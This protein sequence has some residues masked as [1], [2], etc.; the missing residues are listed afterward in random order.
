MADRAVY[1]GDRI[2][3]ILGQYDVP[4]EVKQRILAETAGLKRP[5]TSELLPPNIPVNP[6]ELR[7]QLE[8]AAEAESNQMNRTRLAQMAA[9]VPKGH[10]GVEYTDGNEAEVGHEPRQ[11]SQGISMQ[12]AQGIDQ[13]LQAQA[14]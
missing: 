2:E 14:D 8:N 5:T 10:P 3:D 12:R 1:H 9:G 13:A 6:E 11:P 4:E 7:Q